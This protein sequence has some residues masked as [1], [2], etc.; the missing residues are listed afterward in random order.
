MKCYLIQ[1]GELKTLDKT[2]VTGI[3]ALVRYQYMG[4][5]EFEFGSLHHSFLRI[6]EKFDEYGT[7]KLETKRYTKATLTDRAFFLTCRAADRQDAQ[8][9]IALLMKGKTRLKDCSY[10][11]QLDQDLKYIGVP[12]VWWDI[13][14]DWILTLCKA[15]H[16]DL[17]LHALRASLLRRKNAIAERLPP[18]TETP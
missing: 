2:A 13:Q 11:D 12:D 14:N 3:D 6:C 15:S 8:D 5:A 4:S 10:L 7:E 17:V 9:A 16:A 1:R 18:T